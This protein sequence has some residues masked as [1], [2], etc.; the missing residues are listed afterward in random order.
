MM[1]LKDRNNAVF[2]TMIMELLCGST[3][4]QENYLGSLRCLLKEHLI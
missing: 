2:M 1:V 4:V 3:E